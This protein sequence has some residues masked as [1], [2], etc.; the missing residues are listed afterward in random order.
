MMRKL[1]TSLCLLCAIALWAGRTLGAP[2]Y[3]YTFDAAAYSASPGVT[4]PVSVYL[5]ETFGPGDTSVLASPGYGMYGTGVQVSWAGT[6]AVRSPAAIAASAAFS[7]LFT[8]TDVTSSYATLSEGWP[9]GV[10]AYGSQ[11]EPD[12]YR[13]LVG[14]FGFTVGTT[15]GAVTTLTTSVF[16]PGLNVVNDVPGTVLDSA[17][18]NATATITVVTPEPCGLVLLGMAALTCFAWRC[19]GRRFSGLSGV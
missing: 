9:T 1:M 2:S 19:W 13:L 14:T 10:T 3:C 17:I 8:V 11:Y 16:M 12:V 5:Q 6:A 18:T 7:P 4:V 15:P